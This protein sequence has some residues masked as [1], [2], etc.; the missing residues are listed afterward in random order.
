MRTFTLPRSISALDLKAICPFTD[1]CSGT[2]TKKLSEIQSLIRF[3]STMIKINN[4]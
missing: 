4:Q 3:S 2:K 1:T